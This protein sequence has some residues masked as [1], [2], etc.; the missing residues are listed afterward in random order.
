MFRWP[1]A[2]NA[3]AVSVFLG[4]H[5]SRRACYNEARFDARVASFPVVL[6]GVGP[7]DDGAVVAEATEVGEGGAE[8]A[9]ADAAAARRV[10][11]AG[12]TEEA[13][14]A[15][16]AVVGGEAFDD[17]VRFAEEERRRLDVECLG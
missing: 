10:R 12:R 5:R 1:A 16:V 9:M 17:A 13:E 3:D 11:D 8:E 6:D 14:A 4:P 7:G 2:E 15:V